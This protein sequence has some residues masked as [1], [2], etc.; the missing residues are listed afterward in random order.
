MLGSPYLYDM[1]EI[2]FRHENKYQITKDGVDYTVRH[3]Q[4]KVSVN[5]VSVGQMKRLM[6]S[7]KGCFLMV[8]R[9]KYA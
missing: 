1:K 2:F 8:V 9:E 4:T 6:N 3:H 7:S 5:L